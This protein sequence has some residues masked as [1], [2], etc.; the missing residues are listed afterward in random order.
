MHSP[1]SRNALNSRLA[2]RWSVH[3]K[4]QFASPDYAGEG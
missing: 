3:Y 4:I 1:D 2:Q